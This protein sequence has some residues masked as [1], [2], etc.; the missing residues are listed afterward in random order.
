MQV[1]AMDIEDPPP[2]L[3]VQLLSHAVRQEP[4]PRALIPAGIHTEGTALAAVPVLEFALWGALDRSLRSSLHQ[5]S[6]PLSA[7]KFDET[8]SLTSF[9]FEEMAFNVVGYALELFYS[10][11]PLMNDCWKACQGTTVPTSKLFEF[12]S[13][14]GSMRFKGR[15]RALAFPKNH[16]HPFKGLGSHDKACAGPLSDETLKAL[17]NLAVGD[18]VLL[19]CGGDAPLDFI[20]LVR[21]TENRLRAVYGDAK[22]FSDPREGPNKQV[23]DDVE[24][25][26]AMVHEGL[27]RELLTQ[28]QWALEEL[29]SVFLI[30]NGKA[31]KSNPPAVKVLCPETFEFSPWTD[32]LY[33]ALP[34][35]KQDE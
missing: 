17:Q 3:A 35:A 6:P 16:Y 12:F 13:V 1:V 10:P 23:H 11:S 32:L 15:R 22:H 7:Q 14:F 33:A 2:D 29:F 4:M 34:Q 5:G 28:K 30:T 24:R 25:K 31:P 21:S 18:G 20:L 27:T 26:A 19:W 9:R 8:L